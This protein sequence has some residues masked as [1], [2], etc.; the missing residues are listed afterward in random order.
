VRAQRYLLDR[1]RHP[2]SCAARQVRPLS[3]SRVPCHGSGESTRFLTGRRHDAGVARK[4]TRIRRP[5]FARLLA[6]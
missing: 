3:S 4:R 6:R 5:S 1:P 2:A